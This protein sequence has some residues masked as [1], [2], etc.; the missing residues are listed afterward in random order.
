MS[1]YSL[2]KPPKGSNVTGEETFSFFSHAMQE[3][4]IIGREDVKFSAE[5]IWRIAMD[6]GAAEF[7]DAYAFDHDWLLEVVEET[8]HLKLEYFCGYLIKKIN[9]VTSCENC[10]R[11]LKG[12]ECGN[13]L[14]QRNKFNV[15][16][17][18]SHYLVALIS[19]LEKIIH[20][21]IGGEIHNL[22]PDTFFKICR[23]IDCNFIDSEFI[24]CA[25]HQEI[26]VLK[27][28]HF[29][30]VTRLYLIIREAKKG[31]KNREKTKELKKHSKLVK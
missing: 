29:Y 25:E 22:Q 27:I 20:S 5:D 3:N 16:H 13:L 30:L 1:T 8:E 4:K 10:I 24:G 26:L 21:E 6:H 7:D 2:L 15:L 31:L 11:S 14:S 17:I 9:R 23:K 19:Y 18:P 12:S 28:T